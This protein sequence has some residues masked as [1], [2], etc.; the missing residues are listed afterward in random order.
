MPKQ[1]QALG[2]DWRNSY[3]HWMALLQR[4]GFSITLQESPR[5][6]KYRKHDSFSAKLQAVGQTKMPLIIDLD[7]NYNDQTK[8]DSE[9]TL[10]SIGVKIP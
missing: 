10:Y 9:G 6:V 5:V 2:F 4:L 3:N 7:F 1:W 8:P